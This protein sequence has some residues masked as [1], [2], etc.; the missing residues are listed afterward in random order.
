M[1][2]EHFPGAFEA[3]LLEQRDEIDALAANGDAPT[4]ENTIL[5]M[6]RAGLTLDRVER[7]FGVARENVTNPAYQALEREWQP[8]RG[9]TTAALR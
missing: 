9:F 1:A 4:F 3:A 7:M 6:E 2:P 8:A 5:A